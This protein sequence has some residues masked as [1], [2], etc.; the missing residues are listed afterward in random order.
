M[1][2]LHNGNCPYFSFSI[3]FDA[4]CVDSPVINNFILQK[5]LTNKYIHNK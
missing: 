2:S 3:S 1:A 5:K 4:V